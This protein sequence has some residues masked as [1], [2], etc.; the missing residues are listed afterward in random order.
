MSLN[1]L[2]TWMSA[3]GGGSW[4]QF[5]GA[6]EELDVEP[7]DPD[8]NGGKADTSVGDL[9]TYQAV[10]FGLERLAHVEFF[11]SAAESEWRVVPPALAVHKEGCH[12][13]GILCGARPLGL[14]ERI[15]Q[16][17]ITWESRAAP[18]MPD[19]VRLLADDLDALKT[20]C[21]AAGVRVQAKAPL[22]LL[23]AIPPVD[24]PRSRIPASAPV[25]PGWTIE[26]F[27]RATR[28]WTARHKETE[29]D[30][31]FRDFERHQT[32]LFRFRM[33]YQRFSYLRWRGQTY[34][35]QVQVGKYAIMRHGRVRDLVRYKP[36]RSLLSVPVGCRPPPL[37]ERAL[38]LCSGLLPDFDRVSG[39]LQYA[40]PPSVA[41]LAAGLLRQEIRTE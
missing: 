17:D 27:L 10:R 39:R 19:R 26:R 12:W 37:V 4:S 3:R 23:A 7:R 9:P 35:V 22:S 13:V 8:Q 21:K 32:G 38:V 24:D 5:R 18:G 15:A 2:L 34:S 14:R 41:R 29:R 28:G 25:T 11:S 33:E 40:V 30:F 6:V 16:D 1:H 31:S 36:A 20:A